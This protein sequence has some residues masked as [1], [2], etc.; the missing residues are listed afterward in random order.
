MIILQVTPEELKVIVNNAVREAMPKDLR[1]ATPQAPIKG[2][3]ALGKFLGVGPARAQKLKNEGVFPYFQD[4]R[5]VLFDPD[6][7]R[8]AMA[9]RDIKR[10]N[11]K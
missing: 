9:G 7:V 3:H 11:S 2:I 1:E 5:L 4:G 10:K 8:E 6:K